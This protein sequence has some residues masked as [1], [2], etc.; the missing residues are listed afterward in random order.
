MRRAMDHR[1]YL[2]CP[3]GR[4]VARRSWALWTTDPV[5]CG[6][7][8]W[9]WVHEPDLELV[10]AGFESMWSPGMAPR[11]N[12][13]TDTSRL[14]GID[15]AAF[16]RF[17]SFIAKRLPDL[18]GK[19]AR[20]AIV[21]PAGFPGA[22]VAGF[23]EVSGPPLYPMR[24][25]T[26]TVEALGWLGC[27]DAAALAAELGAIADVGSAAADELRK[28]H[29]LLA[30]RLDVPLGAAARAV[31]V[32]TRSLQRRLHDAGTSFRGEV[33]AARVRAARVLLADTDQKIT[34]IALDVGC[35]SLQ[36]FSALFRRLT[37][38]TPSAWRARQRSG[39]SP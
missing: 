2:A 4:Y 14:K 1:E 23:Y 36:H 6:S 26:T 9:G 13:L 21:R 24:L 32:S 8:V 38:E 7:V 17:A 29:E 25:F 35:A 37:G 12:L 3:V 30:T 19:I 15:A 20:Q 16:Q 39:A 27:D 10:L 18:G 5:L 33:E 34:D 11:C 22:V 31:G 28:L